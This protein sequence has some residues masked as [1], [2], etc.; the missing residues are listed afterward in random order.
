MISFIPSATRGYE[1]WTFGF[2]ADENGDWLKIGP[3]SLVGYVIENKNLKFKCYFGFE[4]HWLN[5]LL[6]QFGSLNGNLV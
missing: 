3:I 4:I 2:G 1:W 6:M 5:R